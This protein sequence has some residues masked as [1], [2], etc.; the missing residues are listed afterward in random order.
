MGDPRD[1]LTHEGHEALGKNTEKIMKNDNGKNKK[2]ALATKLIAG[3]KKRFTNGSQKLPLGGVE[4]TVDEVT[5]LLQSFVDN[6]VA[7]ETAK[8]ATSAKVAVED[9]QA[10]SL[11]AVMTAFVAFVRLTFGKQADALA[12]FGLA[13]PKAR[14]PMTAEQKAVAAAK[15]VATRAARGTTSKKAKKTVKGN[16]TAKLVVTPGTP[17]A[18]SPPVAPPAPVAPAASAAGSGGAPPTPHG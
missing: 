5:T 4:R 10:P 15:R 6:R 18:T 2:A 8:A 13:P 17:P 7:V 12:D 3:A 9:A 16:V 11:L 14:V 1:D